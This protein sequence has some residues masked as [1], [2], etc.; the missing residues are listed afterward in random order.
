[1]LGT[2]ICWASF[3]LPTTILIATLLGGRVKVGGLIQISIVLI[4]MLVLA[5]DRY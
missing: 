2:Y 5:S 3:G 1:M 4:L